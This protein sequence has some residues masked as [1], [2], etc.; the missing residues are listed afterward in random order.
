MSYESLKASP[1]EIN[2]SMQ[3]LCAIGISGPL[4]QQQ[5]IELLTAFQLRNLVCGVVR[6]DNAYRL[7]EINQNSK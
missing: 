4:S 3:K 2:D 1:V 5:R 6:A 7:P